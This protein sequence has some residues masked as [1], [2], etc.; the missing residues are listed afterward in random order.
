MTPIFQH[1]MHGLVVTQV[2]HAET[3]LDAFNPRGGLRVV[4]L[5]IH[6]PHSS[7]LGIELRVT[8]LDPIEA[9]RWATEHAPTTSLRIQAPLRRGRAGTLWFG[10]VAFEH[11]AP[12]ACLRLELPFA[13]AFNPN[14]RDCWVTLTTS[15][16]TSAL[17]SWAKEHR[18]MLAEQAVER[19]VQPILQQLDQ[20][21]V[22]A[23]AVGLSTAMRGIEPL[24]S[25]SLLG[26]VA[27]V[28]FTSWLRAWA[29]TLALCA[30]LLKRVDAEMV[31]EAAPDDA[32]RWQP[33]VQRLRLLS[34]SGESLSVS[35]RE[36]ETYWEEEDHASECARLRA[37]T[38][39][40]LDGA[41]AVVSFLEDTAGLMLLQYRTDGATTIQLPRASPATSSTTRQ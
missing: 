38:G 30:P 2:P 11:G 37:V 27:P 39:A 3:L 36:S 12:A 6:R 26:C 23:V 13:A 28:L 40:S 25:A 15:A 18:A 32:L 20:F 16:D 17:D 22:E 14:Q 33:M 10:R 5:S 7:I 29:H 24:K 1:A 4:D 35:P 19:I 34:T 8:G 41:A 31:A 21:G 9:E